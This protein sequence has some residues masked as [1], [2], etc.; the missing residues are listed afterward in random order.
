MANKSDYEVTLPGN[1][2]VMTIPRWPLGTLIQINSILWALETGEDSGLPMTAGQRQAYFNQIVL[3]KLGAKSNEEL[4]EKHLGEHKVLQNLTHLGNEIMRQERRS[5][6][7]HNGW[8]EARLNKHLDENNHWLPQVASVPGSDTAEGENGDPPAD[9]AGVDTKP[10][11]SSGG[12][13][14]ASGKG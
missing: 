11:T 7:E 4:I 1:G 10:R 8:D 14:Q 13:R 9:E 2:Q 3:I 6:L 12:S 5:W